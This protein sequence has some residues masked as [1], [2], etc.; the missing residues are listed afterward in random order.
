MT[1]KL[2]QLCLSFILL[3]FVFFPVYTMANDRVSD[4]IED[5]EQQKEEKVDKDE[6]SIFDNLEEEEEDKEES[7]VGV[8]AWDYIKMLFAL[9]FVVGLLYALLK[10]INGRNRSY[11]KNRLMKNIGGLSLGQQKSIQLIVVGGTYYL[12]G[13]GEDIRL[14][15]EITDP[16]EIDTLLE[17]Y[18]EAEEVPF[19]GPFESLL[20][21]MS[22]F[23]K[24]ESKKRDDETED[25]SEMLNHRLTEI[26]AERKKQFHRL[27]EKEQ[28]EDD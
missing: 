27:T 18:E 13:V 11:G 4:W 17:Y 14:L 23:Q 1:K 9:A 15:K 28:S 12:V 2:L 22:P 26:K 8:T 7:A 24:K 21:K 5:K 16:D 25:F 6:E 20:M 3:S 10:F 19:K